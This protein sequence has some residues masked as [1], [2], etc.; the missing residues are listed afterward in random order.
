MLSERDWVGIVSCAARKDEEG[1]KASGEEF[2]KAY[3]NLVKEMEENKKN[4]N[5][6]TYDVGYEA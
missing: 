2:Y 3:L 1:A 5:T 4:G 6:G